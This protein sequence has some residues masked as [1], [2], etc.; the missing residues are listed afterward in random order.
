MKTPLLTVVGKKKCNE[1]SENK[2]RLPP[3]LTELVELVLLRID[4]SI[5]KLWM[6]TSEMI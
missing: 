4:L 3:F 2:I 5:S 1:I 6:L